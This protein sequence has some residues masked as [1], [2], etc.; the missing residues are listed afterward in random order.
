M[1]QQSSINSSNAI[2]RG[3]GS[4]SSALNEPLQHRMKLVSDELCQQK[5]DVEG[6]SQFHRMN[7]HPQKA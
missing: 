7:Q 3:F 6:D 1:N 2:Q 5:S 4:K